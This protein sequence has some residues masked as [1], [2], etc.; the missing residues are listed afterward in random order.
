MVDPVKIDAI[1]HWPKPQSVMEVLSFLGLAAFYSHFIKGF[2]MIATLMTNYISKDDFDWTSAARHAFLALKEITTC[3]L[4]LRLPNFSKV[5]KLA[6]DASSTGIRGTLNQEG[7]SV[8]FFSGK[9]NDIRQRYCVY[10][11]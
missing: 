1:R 7:H 11:L 5:F 9:F 3:A 8:T 10:A 2:S 6:C 4:V